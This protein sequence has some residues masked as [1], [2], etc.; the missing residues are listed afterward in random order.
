MPSSNNDGSPRKRLTMKPT[1]MSASAG[2][3]TVLVPT[4]LAITPPRSMSPTSTTGTSA[5][6]AKPML[7]MSAARRLTSD[8]EPAPSTRTRSASA[9]SS[10]KLSSTAPKSLGFIAW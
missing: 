10:A 8:A 2:S 7:A 9:V 1:I 5:A 4:R 3:I 6:R